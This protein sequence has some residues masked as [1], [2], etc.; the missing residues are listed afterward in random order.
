MRGDGAESA[1][2]EAAAVRDYAEAD[3][4]EGR[5]AALRVVVRVPRPRP[6]PPAS[7]D[8]PG[9]SARRA[10][11]PAPV[12]AACRAARPA[13]RN[14]RRRPRRIFSCPRR[15][16]RTTTASRRR[17]RARRRASSSMFRPRRAAPR[18]VPPPRAAPLFRATPAP[19]FR[20][21]AG[22]RGCPQVSSGARSRSRNHNAQSGAGSP[23]R[24]RLSA[25]CRPTARVSCCSR[26]SSLGL[27]A[28]PP[29]RPACRR[30]S[31]ASFST[32]CSGSA[33]SPSS[34]PRA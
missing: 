2:A 10:T 19:P 26:L 1:L 24:R 7:A 14:M 31:G 23:R 12:S 22:R 15:L 11:R 13:P 29:L 6:S 34:P 17:S 20:I 4:V 27:G 21:R 3:L 5:N 8:A 32:P 33:S 9:G 28:S 25:E 18:P 30:R 16:R